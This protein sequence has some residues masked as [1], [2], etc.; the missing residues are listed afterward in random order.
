M[1][2][3]QYSLLRQYAPYE[4]PYN[5][6]LIK[7][8]AMYKQ[9]KVD[10][11][12]DKIYQQM[13]Y[14]MGQ[15]IAKP[16][17]RTYMEEKMSVITNNINQKYAGMDL[18]SDGIA[19]SIQGDISQVLDTTVI[20]AIAGT[21]E[22][23]KMQQMLSEKQLNGDKDYS[24]MNAYAAMK[25]YYEWLQDGKSGSRLNPLQYTPYVDYNKEVRESMDFLRKQNKGK[26]IEMPLLDKDGN[27]T[28]ATYETT[29]DTLT[30]QQAASIGML[31]LS[32]N[33]RAQM[34]IEAIYLADS[35]PET[36]SVGS[37][38]NFMDNQIQ[39]TQ[40]YINALSADLKG[41]GSDINK[42]QAIETEI[43]RAKNEMISMKNY[44][45]TL[46]PDT[47]NPYDGARMIVE[48][49]FKNGV[50]QMYAYD[51]TSSII[52]ADEVYWKQQDYDQK[53]RR[54]NLEVEKLALESQYRMEML[55]IRAAEA[56]S[57]I[58]LNEA[59]ANKL[60][61]GT[62]LAQGFSGDTGTIQVVSG[63][64]DISEIDID[65]ETGERFKRVYTEHVTSYN[66]LVSALNPEDIKN[67]RSAIA[68]RKKN[69]T[70]GYTYL[71]DEEAIFKY[72][73][74]SGG[75]ANRI[76]SDTNGTIGVGADKKSKSVVARKAFLDLGNSIHKMDVEN[77]RIKEEQSTYKDQI[78]SSFDA[79]SK[80]AG[81]SN[82]YNVA[83]RYI[84]NIVSKENEKGFSNS[85]EMN[86]FANGLVSYE[87]LSSM[88]PKLKAINDKLNEIDRNGN[89]P[90]TFNVMDYVTL[91]D[92]TGLY[93]IDNNPERSKVM[94]ML[95][96]NMNGLR[97]SSGISNIKM[98]GNIADTY[99]GADEAVK[100]VSEIRKTYVKRTVPD[101]TIVNAE[102]DVKDP[103]R[104]LMQKIKGIF[105]NKGI[106]P[107]GKNDSPAKIIS[108]T[109][110]PD[111]DTD[112]YQIRV[113]HN[114][115]ESDKDVIVVSGKDLRGNDIPALNL[116]QEI[117]IGTYKSSIKQVLFGSDGDSEYYSVVEKEGFPQEY[118]SASSAKSYLMN[119][120][121]T[122]T[123]NKELVTNIS[124]KIDAIINGSS[125]FFTG[126]EGFDSNTSEEGDGY[127]VN[128]YTKGEDGKL[129]R[130]LDYKIKGPKF[131]DKLNQGHSVANQ[132][133]LIHIL[134]R[135]MYEEIINANQYKLNDVREGSMIDLLYKAAK[136]MED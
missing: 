49:N 120:I 133:E 52:K 125:N 18:S 17:A 106:S 24:G 42:K 128:I 112:E 28:G 85:D 78:D 107:K 54:N 83:D 31:S 72:I 126:I 62:G 1:A 98:K 47:Y 29:V 64:E 56:G 30:P 89:N 7:D 65:K 96:A 119:P 122:K 36:F 68:E 74:E 102:M 121:E 55:G 53:E 32:P 111:M 43:Q 2:T 39:S 132:S 84:A 129:N 97:G 10:A 4:S 44:N 81:I 113:N 90:E 123:S 135:S 75:L 26:K 71:T 114:G 76:F 15:D 136:R 21:K 115:K 100:R 41:V 8:V 33:A 48:S 69:P 25:P 104:P 20:N 61:G 127:K 124:N 134:E 101:Q 50:A 16:E 63:T 109:I 86:Y 5:I 108:Y 19:R 58:G 130:L 87:K 105:S 9:G 34:Q 118:A 79:I 3:S 60:A 117:P 92:K 103:N 93:R 40:S 13:D 82:P 99:L 45:S 37:V 80:R 67:I 14:L 46:S 38:K 11:A 116:G 66:N 51:N 70:L 91:D 59:K 131:A 23:K 35:N 77:D 6:D 27:P 12:R 73:D 57:K 110:I 94:S 88:M 95:F 22:G